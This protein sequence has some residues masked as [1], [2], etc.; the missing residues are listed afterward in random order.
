MIRWCDAH[1]CIDAINNTV[2]I[3]GRLSFLET[4]KPH[5]KGFKIAGSIRVLG[6]STFNGR[7][8]MLNSMVKVLIRSRP[9]ESN[10]APHT[11]DTVKPGSIRVLWR[12]GC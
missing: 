12:H 3:P 7:I 6:R 8:G 5:F 1:S 11:K 10:S 4:A 2:E 9:F